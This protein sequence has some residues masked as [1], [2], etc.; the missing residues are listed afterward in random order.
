MDLALRIPE[1]HLIILMFARKGSS[2]LDFGLN[3][4]ANI[5][6]YL[7]IHCFSSPENA[8]FKTKFYQANTL[9]FLR[10]VFPPPRSLSSRK[11]LRLTANGTTGFELAFPASE[12]PQTH[13]S[14]RVATVISL[15]C[16]TTQNN[17]IKISKLMYA[18]TSP[19]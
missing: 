13:A 3:L 17:Y 2:A 14:D 12:R 8:T 10:S 7:K 19:H 16:Y 1:Y 15:R 18:C 9:F 5:Q 4:N 6:I 11:I